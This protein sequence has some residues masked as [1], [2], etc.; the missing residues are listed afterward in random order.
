MVPFMH[1]RVYDYGTNQSLDEKDHLLHF[2]PV[3]DDELAM[4]RG[5]RESLFLL[6]LPFL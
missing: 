6:I 5:N 3:Y 4:M 1:L 2:P